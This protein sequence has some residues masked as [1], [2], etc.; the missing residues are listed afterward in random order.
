MDREWPV[1]ERIRCSK[2]KYQVY[3]I[4]QVDRGWVCFVQ[5]EFLYIVGRE[6]KWF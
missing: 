3:V 5:A 4:L 1:E 6:A 2:C